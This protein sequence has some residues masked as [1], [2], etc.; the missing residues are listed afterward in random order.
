MPKK[1]LKQ[2]IGGPFFPQS[3]KEMV[4]KVEYC[5]GGED[6]HTHKKHE[7]FGSFKHLERVAMRWR[8][9]T[10]LRKTC[11]KQSYDLPMNRAATVRFES[12]GP[13]FS[14]VNFWLVASTTS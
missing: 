8:G 6:T 11:G 12:L 1:H 2:Q 9:T 13:M 5:Y 14:R 10:P 7:Q 3:Q 4:Y